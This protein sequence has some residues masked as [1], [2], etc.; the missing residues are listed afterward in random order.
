M[1]RRPSYKQFLNV[2]SNLHS[3]VNLSATDPHSNRL[4]PHDLS[5]NYITSKPQPDRAWQ[6][7]FL[8]VVKH[9]PN[10]PRTLRHTCASH[11]DNTLNLNS[12]FSNG[13]TASL[14]KAD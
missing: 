9:I 5:P 7:A 4:A 11:T 10:D 1:I 6:N 14:K 13:P 8:D 2:T 3:S 12:S